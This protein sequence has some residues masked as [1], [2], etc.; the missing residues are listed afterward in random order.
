MG[1]WTNCE[2]CSSYGVTCWEEKERRGWFGMKLPDR[3]GIIV[4]GA[5]SGMTQEIS[6]CAGEKGELNPE[7]QAKAI[8]ET[9]EMITLAMG[10]FSHYR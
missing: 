7:Q 2:V 6:D 9:L 4:Y 3:S 5:N 10:T 1:V 8:K